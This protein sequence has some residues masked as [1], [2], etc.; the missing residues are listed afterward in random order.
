MGSLVYQFIELR[1]NDGW[2]L[3]NQPVEWP[4]WM[5]GG[6]R[7]LHSVLTGARQE[8]HGY[9]PI[10]PERGLPNDL[11]H[12]FAA[13]LQ[14]NDPGIYCASWLL[15]SEILHADWDRPFTRQGYVRQTD[16]HRFTDPPGPFPSS[17]PRE[18]GVQYMSGK[19]VELAEDQ[20][21]HVT[22]L[23]NLPDSSVIEMTGYVEESMASHFKVP[24]EVLPIG[25]MRP[26]SRPRYRL[27]T[28]VRWT[29]TY[30]SEVPGFEEFCREQ[31]TQLGRPDEIRLI[32]Y[33][34]C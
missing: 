17:F 9:P 14:Q 4:P 2:H 27:D 18:P 22:W 5:D 25:I 34:F 23:H 10:V 1:T 15:L 8:V 21:T 16:A 12:E 32:I 33:L 13:N 7:R 20:D 29:V 6:H 19:P 24:P 11:S 30:R 31:L 28:P 3:I 26:A